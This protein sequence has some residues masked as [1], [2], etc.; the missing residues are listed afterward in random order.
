MAD[1]VVTGNFGGAALP[2]MYDIEQAVW[3]AIMEYDGRVS[4]MGV[5]GILRLIEHRLL[6][7]AHS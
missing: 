5:I 4:L 6:S 2:L 1:N 7:E 3:N